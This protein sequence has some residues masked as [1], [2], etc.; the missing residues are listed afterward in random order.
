MIMI[1]RFLLILIIAVISK[2]LINRTWIN[3]I[4]QRKKF[5]FRKKTFLINQK[6]K[7]KSVEDK[8]IKIFLEKINNS[9]KMILKQSTSIKFNERL[10]K[11][12]KRLIERLWINE[13]WR[14]KL[15]KVE[16]SSS[17]ILRKEL[18][19]N[20]FYDEISSKCED[21]SI[22]EERIIKIHLII[23]ALF[24]ILFRQKNV[25][26]FVVFM[27]NLKIQLKKH[28]NNTITDSKSIMSFEYHD[29]LNV[30]LKEKVDILSFHNKHDYCMNLE[31]DHESDH[32]YISLYNLSEDE[33]I[34]IKKYFK[35]H[36][37]KNFI[38]SSIVF[39]AI[40]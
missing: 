17:R 36:L 8:K 4:K 6:M 20:S 1:T 5:H 28:D 27:K 26:I 10:N 30:F 39:Y 19:I 37:N 29:F 25:K 34:L 24:N 38:E 21:E 11:R 18:K 7:I 2:H 14:K 15:R 31:S 32:E 23:I 3:Q 22:N 9:S 16:T 12:S 33:L 35:E 40:R 13:S